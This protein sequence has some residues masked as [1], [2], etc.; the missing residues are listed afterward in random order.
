[1]KSVRSRTRSGSPGRRRA[2]E[3]RPSLQVQGP[4]GPEFFPPVR[5]YVKKDESSYFNWQTYSLRWKW[6]RDDGITLKF[7]GRYS[8]REQQQWTIPVLTSPLPPEVWTFIIEDEQARIAAGARPLRRCLRL[9][10]QCLPDRIFFILH[11]PWPPV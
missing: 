11:R 2:K 1:M 6:Q 9:F 5:D 3:D 4:G 7:G 8:R 10:H